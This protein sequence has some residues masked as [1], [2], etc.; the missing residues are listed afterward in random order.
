MRIFS[1]VCSLSHTIDQVI[2]YEDFKFFGSSVNGISGAN[3]F[4][5]S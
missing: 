3:D 2:L 4:G 1:S 5:L